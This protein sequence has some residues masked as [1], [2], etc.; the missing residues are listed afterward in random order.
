MCIKKLNWDILNH[1]EFQVIDKKENSLFY[2]S[3]SLWILWKSIKTYTAFWLFKDFIKSID[4]HFFP[5]VDIF[6]IENSGPFS[7]TK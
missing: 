2:F 4:V 7:K 1:I 5:F 3:L 6:I